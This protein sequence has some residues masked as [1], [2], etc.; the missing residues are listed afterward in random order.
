MIVEP[1]RLER[2]RRLAGDCLDLIPR[3]VIGDGWHVAWAGQ[4]CATC[5]LDHV[6]NLEIA[7]VTI[8]V[9]GIAVAMLVSE[10]PE[11]TERLTLLGEYVE[12]AV[13]A[14]LAN[15]GLVAAQARLRRALALGAGYGNELI[16]RVVDHIHA[17][18]QRPLSLHECASL[19][20]LSPVYLSGLFSRTVGVPFKTYLTDLRLEKARQLLQD[21]AR[22]VSEVAFAVGYRD[23]N[24]FRLAFK[25]VTGVSPA[26]WRAGLNS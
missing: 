9:E 24:R 18:Y 4:P 22:R 14:R 23:A 26:R 13:S 7:A 5:T 17:N 16:A 19:V 2:L 12:A 21:P 10:S 25:N 11:M 1:T 8:V 15:A 6:G 3:G 20:R